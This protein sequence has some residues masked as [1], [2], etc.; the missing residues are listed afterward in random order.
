MRSAKRR[1]RSKSLAAIRIAI[2]AIVGS[3]GAMGMTGCTVDAT[4]EPLGVE[5]EFLGEIGCATQPCGFGGDNPW[6]VGKTVVPGGPSCSPPQYFVTEPPFVPY[7]T[8]ACPNAM[9]A[10]LGGVEDA[11]GVTFRPYIAWADT[12]L[13]SGNCASAKLDMAVYRRPDGVSPWTTTTHRWH[14]VWNPGLNNCDFVLNAGY[15]EP[16]QYTSTTSPPGPG[17]CTSQIKVAGTAKVGSTGYRL[18]AVGA[19]N[20]GHGPC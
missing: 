3:T 19:R 10:W 12:P 14:G 5:D 18:V 17:C 2:V 13:T 7:G 16:A 6:C 20:G 11:P 8:A 9:V 15:T 4:G 1:G